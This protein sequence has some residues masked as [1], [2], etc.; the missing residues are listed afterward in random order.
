MKENAEAHPSDERA[1]KLTELLSPRD[2]ATEFC[3]VLDEREE[4]RQQR[5]KQS[6]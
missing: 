2:L 6:T 5:E 3:R 1:D 4:M